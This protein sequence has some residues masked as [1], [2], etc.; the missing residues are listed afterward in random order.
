MT[1]RIK[2]TLKLPDGSA[3]AGVDIEFISRRNYSPLL[4]DLSSIIKTTSTG[5]YDITL[6][7][8]EYAVVVCWGCNQPSHI[9][10]LFVFSDTVPGLDLQ[11]LLQQADWQPATPE[12]IQQIQDWLAQAGASASQ[13][14]N[15]AA[16]AKTS[17]ITSEKEANRAKSEADKAAQAVID[18]AVPFP[19]VWIPFNDSLRMFAGY[20]R[21]VKVGDDV[22][23]RMVN[24][25]RSTTAT[26]IDK[27]GV[28]RTAAINEPRFEKQGLLIEGQS[29]N[30]VSNS[31]NPPPASG[32]ISVTMI[33][34]P[35]GDV[36][37]FAAAT[38][39]TS[40]K[41]VKLVTLTSGKLVTVSF[42][43]KKA[44]IDTVAVA[45]DGMFASLFN[46]TSGSVSGF[47]PSG[48]SATLT[49]IG[50][51]FYKATVTTTTTLVVTPS[52]RLKLN[53]T[54]AANAIGEGMLIGN[55]QVEELPFA[56]SYI[57]TNGTAVTRAADKLLLDGINM[58]I[59]TKT[60]AVNFTC[61]VNES[62]LHGMTIF[63]EDVFA[64]SERQTLAVTTK[65]ALSLNNGGGAIDAIGAVI[66][67]A[68]QV[69]VAVF[70]G[71]SSKLAL[72]GIVSKAQRVPI[73]AN[74]QIYQQAWRIGD[75][76]SYSSPIYGHIRNLRI[77]HHALSDA[78]I[79][80]L[81]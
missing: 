59:G 57:P 54:Y 6:Q 28:L 52:L 7:Y 16:A 81:K 39:K 56:S 68:P 79:K 26:Y 66:S 77:W 74:N 80:G 50:D 25:E 41:E 65:G 63:R 53:G 58:P 11:T 70:N 23:A 55:V 24:Y 21:E 78:Q 8:G 42:I 10:K 34:S 35:L 19:D 76:T 73:T 33:A 62:A 1:Y 29:T 38:T 20:G 61:T 27:S 49:P 9:G 30:L 60:F 36:F 4:M 32:E 46:L 40:M 71:S 72:N 22:V 13:A 14:V 51:G 64:A 43:A 45:F 69:A 48:S 37:K 17:A 2:G 31:T 3:A 5:A 47:I 12:Y 15:S 44:E 67:K 75:N 18:S